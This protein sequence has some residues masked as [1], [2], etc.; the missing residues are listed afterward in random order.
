[1]SS[2]WILIVSY[3]SEEELRDCLD[4][5]SGLVEPPAGILV[6]ENGRAP[7]PPFVDPSVRWVQA[8][9]NLGYAGGVNLGLRLIEAEGAH[10]AWLL[11]PDTRVDRGAL[12]ALL[13]RIEGDPCLGAVGSV[14]FDLEAPERI[15]AWGGGWVS[16]WGQV[17]LYTRPVPERRLGYLTGA[18]LL[19]RLSALREVGPLDEGF[20][21]YFEDTDLSLRL[22]RAG[23]RLGVA[24]GSWVWHQGQAS[25]KAQVLEADRRFSASATRFWSKH[26]RCPELLALWALIRWSLIYL[27]QGRWDRLRAHW[28]GLRRGGWKWRS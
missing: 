15:Q 6:V 18:S 5:L 13:E 2:V 11:N 16:R 27:P 22:R 7:R 24:R 12:R 26:F 17:G 19:L 23:Y 20:F 8:P 28:E 4:S 3:R 21:M 1:M 25:W 14:L 10:Y 9:R